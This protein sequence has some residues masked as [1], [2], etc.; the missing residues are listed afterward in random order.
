M[1]SVRL[2]FCVTVQV[3]YHEQQGERTIDS[4]RG[5]REFK[6]IELSREMYLPLL[7]FLNFFV[8][9]IPANRLKYNIISSYFLFWIAETSKMHLAF[10]GLFTVYRFYSK[11]LFFS[12]KPNWIIKS[13]LLLRMI[14]E[15]KFVSDSIPFMGASSWLS[16]YD[17]MQ[18]R[19]NAANKIYTELHEFNHER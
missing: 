9:I 18:M 19:I 10:H 1:A 13:V 14:S 17:I 8:S 6:A 16:F 12:F 15:K 2:W 7:F 3:H 11:M 5:E 4:E